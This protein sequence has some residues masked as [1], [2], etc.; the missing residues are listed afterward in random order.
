[1]PIM[2]IKELFNTFKEKILNLFSIIKDYYSENKKTSLIIT[3]LIVVIL[4]CLIIL[5]A[6]LGSKQKNQDNQNPM[7]TN[8][9]LSEELLVPNGPQLPRNYNISRNTK[10]KWSDEEAESWFTIPSQTD[11]NSLSTSNDNR[12]KEILEVAP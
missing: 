3:A 5:I 10:D 7:D 6:S 2:D 8:L 1:M 11:I 12:I 4:M 9:I